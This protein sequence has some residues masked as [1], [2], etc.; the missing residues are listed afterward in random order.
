FVK[1]FGSATHV[2][3]FVSFFVR[4]ESPFLRPDPRQRQAVARRGCQ[5]WPADQPFE[6]LRSC[7]ATP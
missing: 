7:E 2:L 6:M 5:G 3:S 4:S 1:K